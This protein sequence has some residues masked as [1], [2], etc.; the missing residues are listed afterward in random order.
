MH[1]TRLAGREGRAVGRDGSSI[2]DVLARVSKDDL[3]ALDGFAPVP[4]VGSPH[5]RQRADVAAGAVVDG[6][7]RAVHVHLAVADEVEPRP[8]EQGFAGGRGRRDGEVIRVDERAAAHDRLDD[9]EGRA[10][11]VAE[12]DLA[13]ASAV[14]GGAA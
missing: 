4:D 2:L 1:S 12:R 14:S 7:G 6:N 9:L 8:R 11:V 3:P 5:V 10:V 13:R